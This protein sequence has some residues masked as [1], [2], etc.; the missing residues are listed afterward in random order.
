MQVK[1][2]G[3]EKVLSGLN[4]KSEAV[5]KQV[6]FEFK[7]AARQ[8]EGIA[9]RN[10]PVNYGMVRRSITTKGTFLN[11]EVVAQSPIAV[12]QEFGTGKYA[13]T[14]TPAEFLNY[15]ASFKGISIPNTGTLYSNILAWVK[16]KN[17][18][19]AGRKT[20][21][22]RDREQE[23]IAFVIA[24]SIFR[25]GVRPHPFLLNAFVEVRAKLIDRILKIIT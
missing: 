25:D 24:R 19:S 2:E 14:K 11:Y 4:K 9:K 20:K 1:I 13:G 15:A 16:R 8:I 18:K 12:V 17:I 3:L 21:A 6:D 23:G 10:A 5:K 7:D 22:K